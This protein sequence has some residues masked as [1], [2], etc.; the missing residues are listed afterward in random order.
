MAVISGSTA[1]S[2]IVSLPGKVLKAR[3]DQ[4]VQSAPAITRT[5]DQDY[6]AKFVTPFND[7]DSLVFSSQ[8]IVA[9]TGLPSGS[10]LIGRLVA[11]PNTAPTL[12]VTQPVEVSVL[13]NETMYLDPDVQSFRGFNDSRVHVEAGVSGSSFYAIGTD[14]TVVPGFDSPLSSKVQIV[15]DLPNSTDQVL[16]RNDAERTAADTSGEFYNQNLTGFVYYNFELGRWEQIGLTDPATG[17]SIHYDY[18]AEGV[19][20]NISLLKSGTNNFPMQFRQVFNTKFPSTINNAATNGN[21]KTG[22]PTIASMAPFKTTYHATSSQTLSMENYISHPFLFEKAVLEFPFIARHVYDG[23]F[24]SHAWFQDNYV[25]FMYRQVSSAGADG[26]VDSATAVTAS[27]RFLVCS[28]SLAIYNQNGRRESFSGGT[29]SNFTQFAPTNSPAQSFNLEYDARAPLT[30]GIASVTGTMRLEIVPAVT[31]AQDLAMSSV[32]TTRTP[33]LTP[34][35]VALGHSWPGGT[36]ALPFFEL[37]SGYTGKDGVSASYVGSAV[38]SN[39]NPRTFSQWPESRSLSAFFGNMPIQTFDSKALRLLGGVNSTFDFGGGLD[40]AAVVAAG[41]NSV[42]SPYLLLPEDKLVFGFDAGIGTIFNNEDLTPYMITG[43]FCKLL[44]G[45]GKLTLFGSMI[46]NGKEYFPTTNQPLTTA[47]IQETLHFDNPVVDQYLIERFEVFTGSNQEET[48]AGG[49]GISAWDNQFDGGI[50]GD[51]RVIGTR[52]RGTLGTTGSL[53]R[54]DRIPS[55][56]ERF[57]DDGKKNSAVFRFDHF[58]HARDMFEPAVDGTFS[59]DKRQ[60]NTGLVSPPLFVRFVRDGM[61]T[62]PSNTF[63]QNLS[64]YAT[65]SFVYV[66]NPAS[67]LENPLPGQDRGDIPDQTINEELEID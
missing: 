11:T 57:A 65:S 10:S 66:D 8:T 42:V 37:E 7:N 26:L 5:G 25:F 35:Q 2:G 44:A 4:N 39:V 51:R 18:A 14:I 63:S 15:I 22:L 32:P 21:Q 12:D 46:Q 29:F 27:T 9:G 52:N 38:S 62:D 45:S 48:I 55:E 20:G 41:E 64:T 28:A 24:Q 13:D 58:G 56:N 40:N 23:D 43:S 53:Q 50:S 49:Y 34:V 6:A 54:F 60:K 3:H 67:T 47:E 30:A 17:Q 1:R 31:P 36:T 33:G 59:K 61:Q 19:A 16:T